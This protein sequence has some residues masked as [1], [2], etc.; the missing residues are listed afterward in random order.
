[1]KQSSISKKY[2]LIFC[3]ICA[4]IIAFF[5]CIAKYGYNGYDE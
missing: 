4:V 1:M 3:V 2:D 5:V